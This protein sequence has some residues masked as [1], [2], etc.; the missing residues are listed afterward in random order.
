MPEL[1][2]LSIASLKNA[3]KSD[4]VFKIDEDFDFYWCRDFLMLDLCQVYSG[5]LQVL[6]DYLILSYFK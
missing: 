2:Q 3:I 4:T 5:Y 6:L 1:H